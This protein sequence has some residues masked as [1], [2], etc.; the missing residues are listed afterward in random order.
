MTLKGDI[1][2]VTV[3]SLMNRF[4]GKINVFCSQISCIIY[5]EITLVSP[6]V[7]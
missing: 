2:G 6:I 5:I 3:S 7:V 1:W 4:I